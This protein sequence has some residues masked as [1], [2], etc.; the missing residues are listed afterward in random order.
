MTHTSPATELGLW[1]FAVQQ[2]HNMIA[3]GILGSDDNVELLEGWLVAKMSKNPPHSVA[4]ALTRAYFEKLGL[5]DCYVRSQEP[6]TLTDSEP[7]PDVAVVRGHLRDY[8]AHHPFTTDVLLVAEISD[9][10]LL[11]RKIAPNGLLAL[12]R[13]R[14][15]K[16]GIYAKA[17]IGMYW[18][19]NLPARKLEVYS[20]PVDGIYTFSEIYSSVKTAKLKLEET[21][22]T[23]VVADLLP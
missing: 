11:A 12:E 23:V 14:T 21:M 3:K 20:V 13:D 1:R 9:S 4:N 10:T 2:Y 15:W 17:G 7:E 8:T 16:Q 18:I 5:V 6:I 22:L 19:L